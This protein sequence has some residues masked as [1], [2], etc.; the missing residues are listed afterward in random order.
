[1]VVKRC[2]EHHTYDWKL[3]IKTTDRAQELAVKF[4]KAL[5][6]DG[7]VKFGEMTPLMVMTYKSDV[8]SRCSQPA[9]HIEEWVVVKEFLIGE[10]TEWT[11]KDGS[12]NPEIGS[13]ECALLIAFSHYSLVESG[14][15]VL[16]TNLQGVR[17]NPHDQLRNYHKGH[18]LADTIAGIESHKQTSHSYQLTDPVIHSPCQEYGTNDWG[19]MGIQL[20][21]NT[22]KCNS[23][24]RKLGIDTK[25]Q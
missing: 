9:F 10:Y 1:M 23:Y 22:H 3:D 24:C 8:F 7:L 11:L 4:N 16:V 21:L 15:E 2:K 14:R 25:V 20:F 13:H 18:F 12:A 5:G 17:N 19:D 6:E